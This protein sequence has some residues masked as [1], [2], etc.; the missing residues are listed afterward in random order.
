[1]PPK[2]R[3][4]AK[5]DV[6]SDGDSEDEINPTFNPRMDRVENYEYDLDKV[7]S[8]DEEIDESEAFNTDDDQKYSEAFQES[9]S[10]V[11]QIILNVKSL[12]VEKQSRRIIFLRTVLVKTVKRRA[13]VKTME[14]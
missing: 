1:M 11:F 8:D 5:H 10:K 6:Y 9:S 7:I 4:A 14:R 2:K 12:V 13:M 3:A